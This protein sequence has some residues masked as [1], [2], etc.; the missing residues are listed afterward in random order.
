MIAH[1]VNSL[2]NFIDGW[3]LDDTTICDD[4]IQL[5]SDSENK[6]E[7]VISKSNAIP[8]VDKYTKDSIDVSYFAEENKTVKTYV[9][10][11]L[12]LC[13]NKYIEKYEYCN[14][15]SPWTVT[16]KIN[17][18]HYKPNGGFFGWHTERMTR[19]FPV[20]SRHLVF[21]TYLNTVKDAGETEFHY[22]NVKI[23]PV[24]G[25][26]LIWPADWTF[27]HRGIASPTENKY[28]ITGWFGF[29]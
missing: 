29:T 19:D 2:N 22:Q 10:K 24:K 21:M 18:Q 5:H 3:Y 25:L 6:V 13:V 26:T 23:R 16:E 8:I 7:G 27:T 14:F 28:I 20:S 12:Q 15:Y 11:H 17:I 4:L 1:T 9:D